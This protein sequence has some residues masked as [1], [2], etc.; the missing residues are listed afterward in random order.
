MKKFRKDPTEWENKKMTSQS[1]G[2]DFTL[3]TLKGQ[4]LIGLYRDYDVFFAHWIAINRLGKLE[5]ALTLR[6]QEEWHE[7]MG[8]C[9]WF[10][11]GKIVE[12]PF[13]VGGLLDTNFPNDSAKYFVQIPMIFEVEE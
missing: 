11:D 3:E 8:A 10:R 6:K 2:G 5:D 7:D 12:P 13:Y 9:L 1:V 4:D